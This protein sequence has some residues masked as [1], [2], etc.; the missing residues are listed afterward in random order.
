[1]ACKALRLF[2]L[3]GL[4]ACAFASYGQATTSYERPKVELPDPLYVMNSTVIINGLIAS[5]DPKDI[6]SINVYKG[7]DEPP[8]LRNL[9]PAGILDITCSKRIKS[10]SFAQ[11]GRR[12]GLRGPSI[13]AINGY[14]VSAAALNS[15]RIAPEAI[16]QIHI[17]QATPESPAT[18][19]DI[20]LTPFKAPN[21]SKHPPGTI[22]IR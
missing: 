1:M 19:V 2:C 8:Q 17:T 16:G 6:E 20:W 15:L 13:F 5:F 21:T 7:K 4:C 9:G 14:P 22:M 11:I 10:E 3:V 12:L 18:R